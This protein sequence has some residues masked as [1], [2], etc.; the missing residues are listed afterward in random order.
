MTKKSSKKNNKKKVSKVSKRKVSN[1]SKRKGSKVSKRKV[2]KRKVKRKRHKSS[3]KKTK[4]QKLSGGTLPGETQL[5]LITTSDPTITV[6]CHNIGVA[7]QEIKSEKV[8]DEW[9]QKFSDEQR[10]NLKEII[11]DKY[12]FPIQ[13][14]AYLPNMN[15]HGL[16]SYIN[17]LF[18]PSGNNPNLLLLQEVFF[19][20]D[21]VDSYYE[22][23]F[24]ENVKQKLGLQAFKDLSED[25]KEMSKK[26]QLRRLQDKTKEGQEELEKYVTTV[27]NTIADETD[28]DTLRNIT[29]YRPD[30]ISSASFKFPLNHKISPGEEHQSLPLLKQFRD[31]SEQDNIET[32]FIN[33]SCKNLAELTSTNLRYCRYPNS[34]YFQLVK[35]GEKPDNFNSK[36]KCL[37]S[38]LVIVFDK[39]RFTL[40]HFDVLNTKRGIVCVLQDNSLGIKLIVVNLQLKINSSNIKRILNI[41]LHQLLKKNKE[42]ESLISSLNYVGIIAF[43]NKNYPKIY[44]N[45]KDIINLFNNESLE[46]IEEHLQ[47]IVLDEKFKDQIRE[48]LY[49]NRNK[50]LKII[51]DLTTKI[52][53]LKAKPEY[54]NAK[55]I[56]GGD[57]NDNYFH[58]SVKDK[59][60]YEEHVKA[61]SNVLF[62]NYDKVRKGLENFIDNVNP[63]FPLT[64]VFKD[65]S[66]STNYFSKPKE[67]G[68]LTDEKFIEQGK[69][70]DF[71]F[72]DMAYTESEIDEEPT[73]LT[74]IQK[75]KASEPKI[76]SKTIARKGLIISNPLTGKPNP[77]LTDENFHQFG[78][79][80][81]LKA[82]LKK[83]VEET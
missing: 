17:N 55:I 63:G 6:R 71:L 82:V 42:L 18:T 19:E 35:L 70:V 8:D 14:Q 48:N 77:P 34:D 60:L 64:N 25:Q 50:N 31:N 62:D 12:K 38:N 46:P 36:Y 51:A 9:Y 27:N 16:Q 44:N 7:S 37:S 76:E 65:N 58:P 47:K 21:S 49:G 4:K 73:K 26:I 33:P 20:D 83:P 79:H 2:S 75:N 57:F 78:D 10:Y 5:P 24:N 22:P 41:L 39:S 15:S 1:V 23:M 52:K 3:G 29:S 30:K 68:L 59:P 54:S 72:T 69:R 80:N 13:P 61:F 11:T 32:E 81:A 40:L 28:Y 56:L 66:Q 43:L 53:E 45:I 74:I 67:E